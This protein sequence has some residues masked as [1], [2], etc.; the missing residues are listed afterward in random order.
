[1]LAFALSAPVWPILLHRDQGRRAVSTQQGVAGP[2]LTNEELCELMEA[3]GARRD[4]RAFSQLFAFFAPRVKGFGLRRGVSPALAEDIAQEAMLTVWHKA[5]TFDR[6][7]ASVSTWVFTIVRNKH[8]DMFRRHPYPELDIDE[9]AET[10][11]EAEPADAAIAAVQDSMAVR[12]AMRGLPAE[13][14]L[15]IQKAFYEDKSHRAIADEL[16]L[17]LGTVKS[18][19]RLALARMRGALPEAIH[20]QG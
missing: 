4:R 9:L 16:G 11:S 6:S 14:L 10:A 2:A 18:R 3:V 5:A 13:Q 19:I 17:P 1:M 7:K 20:D 15:I 8:I 12:H